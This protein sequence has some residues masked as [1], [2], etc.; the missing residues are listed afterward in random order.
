MQ[1]AWRSAQRGEMKPIYVHGW[2]GHSARTD[3]YQ[4]DGIKIYDLGTGHLNDLEISAG[5]EIS[6]LPR[7]DDEVLGQQASEQERE[8]RGETL[9]RA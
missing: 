2:V 3:L 7:S 1:D 8:L 6:P 4:A 5:P 9:I